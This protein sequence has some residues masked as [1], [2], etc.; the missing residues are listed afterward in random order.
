MKKTELAK[1]KNQ[2][3]AE[4]AKTLV[5]SRE[6]LVKLTHEIAGNKVKNVHSANALRRDIARIMT[7][8]QNKPTTK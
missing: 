7:L 2:T 6:K 5:E 1:L 8:M 4:L 3:A